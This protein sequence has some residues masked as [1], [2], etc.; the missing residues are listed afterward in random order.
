MHYILVA[1]LLIFC[2]LSLGKFMFI[3][4]ISQAKFS[5]WLTRMECSGWNALAKNA[6]EQGDIKQCLKGDCL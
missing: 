6:H 4:F 5:A 1:Y 2:L 3:Y